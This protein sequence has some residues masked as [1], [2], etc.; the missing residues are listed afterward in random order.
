MV[1]VMTRG[2]RAYFGCSAGEIGWSCTEAAQMM[3][4][5]SME[6]SKFRVDFEEQSGWT[7]TGNLENTYI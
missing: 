5:D 1:R 7:R 4:V 2:L 3:E 6:N